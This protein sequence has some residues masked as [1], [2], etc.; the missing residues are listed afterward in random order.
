MTV[1]LTPFQYNPMTSELIAYTKLG[2]RIKFVGG[3][4][5]F[6]EERLRSRFWEPILANHLLNY[7][8]LP[9]VDFDQLRL[10]RSGPEYLIITP[11]DPIFLAWADTI[12]TWRRLQGI[13]TEIFSTTEIG[14][15]T[16]AA[17]EGWLDNAYQNWDPAPAAFLILGDYPG[18]GFRQTGITSPIWNS[19]CVSDN[20]YADVNADNLPDMVHA[21]I[22]ARD[23]AELAR[24]IGKFLDYERNPPTDPAYYDHPIMAGGWQTERWFIL[25]AEVCLGHQEVVLGKNPVR[26]Y[27]IYDGTPGSTWSSNP[28]TSQVV[29]YFGPNGLG[30]IPSTPQ[31]L[32]DWGGNATRIN[33]DINSG[34]YLML[35]RDHGYELG[36]GEPNYS[37]SDLPGLSNELLPF[38]FSM[39]CLTGKYNYSGETFTEAFHRMEHGALGLIAASEISYSFVND[40]LVWGL[41][42][43]MWP[44]FMPDYGPYPP[45][46]GFST[47]LRPAF[48]MANG[49]YFLQASSWPYNPGDKTVTYHLFH[50]HSDAFLQLYSEVPQAMNVTHDD[51]CFLG[52]PTFQVQAELGAFIALTVEGEIIGTADATGFPQDIAIDP[53]ML[54]GTLDITVTKANRFRYHATLPIV[55]A[56]GPYLVFAGSEVLDGFTDNDATLDA[57]ETVDLD[58]VLHNVGVD[59]TTSVSATIS[60]EDP[61]VEILVG[62]APY[63]DIPSDSLR[64][65]LEPF[66]LHASG[67]TPDGHVAT[68]LLTSQAAEG[69]WESAFSLMIQAPVLTSGATL[70][71]DSVPLGDGD[72][73]ADPGETIYL[74]LSAENVGSSDAADL[75]ATLSCLDPYVLVL[76]DEGESV[77]I[78]AGG[79]GLFSAFQLEIL[80][81]CPTPRMVG[82]ILSI[83]GTDGFTASLAY[84]IAIGP[85][86]DDVEADRGWTLTSAGDDAATGQ[87]VRVDPNG[88]S[89]NGSPCQP[90]DDHTSDPGTDCF[91]TGNG[92]IGG[93]AGEADVDGGKTTLSTPVFDLSNALSATVSYW[94]WYTNDLGNNPGEDSWNVD[95]T[96]GGGS[97]L[98]LENTQESAA[99]WTYHEFVIS[100]FLPM[101]DQVQLR[102][103]A[104]DV[105][106]GGSLVEAAVDDFTLTAI[107]T[108]V[109]DARAT[110]LTSRDGIISYSP[111][112]FN[113]RIS[114]RYRI[115]SATRVDL[116]VYDVAGRLVRTLVDGRIE[117]GQSTVVFDGNDQN[118]KPVSSGIYFLRFDT[119]QVLEVR[120]IALLK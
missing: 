11:D 92:S 56:E 98:P 70:I 49:K 63:P 43:G 108:P 17:I 113:P 75:T 48:G 16:A 26:E 37:N 22:V 41:F 69:N 42:D 54:P 23:E 86:S 112:P 52:V 81:L 91:V 73:G 47:D 97:W 7:D 57:G 20:I 27:A 12:K 106:V 9:P 30:Y 78:M 82:V 61:Y 109:T 35:H 39:N 51:V 53:Q 93:A 72:G 31:H 105:G 40:C 88:T 65:C 114:I 18:T 89:Y 119:P 96:V 1:G 34:A 79:E 50:H 101:T 76:D 83:A 84:E 33:N 10:D 59:P 94:R 21:R 28:N 3:N 90:E 77:R 62:E 85:W 60:T 5:Q 68:F 25:C 2:I 8:L 116:Q 64:A 111:N 120:Q 115:A 13:E 46:T 71:D 103:I 80:P 110:G 44:G 45:E 29:N 55:P 66:Q 87:W 36:W 19:Y 15:E 24:M 58:I 99:S 100:D 104:S 117:A 67:D 107:R 4:G 6:G 74:Q 95:V 102:F 32:T 14:G 118:G 38:V